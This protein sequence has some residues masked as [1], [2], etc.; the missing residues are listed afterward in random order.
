VTLISDLSVGGLG[1]LFLIEGAANGELFEMYVEQIFAPTLHPEEIVI[2]DN[3]SIHKRKKVRELIEA[4]GCQLLFLP[5][6]SPD[7][8]PIEE[9]FSKIKSVLRSIRARDPRK[10]NCPRDTLAL[11]AKPLIPEPVCV[12]A[13]GAFP[14]Q[15]ARRGWP[16]A[17]GCR[18]GERVV[19]LLADLIG[20]REKQQ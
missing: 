4:K 9:A 12:S 14:L 1:E 11:C 17:G 5:A 3:L 6:Y 10:L 13:A 15:D 7:F 16:R 19:L 2:M 8:S 20:D 18:V